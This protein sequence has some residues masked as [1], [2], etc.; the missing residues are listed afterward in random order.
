MKEMIRVGVVVTIIYT[1]VAA[2]MHLMMA[3]VL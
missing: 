2:T 3:S 1:T